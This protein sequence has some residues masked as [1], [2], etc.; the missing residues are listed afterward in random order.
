MGIRIRRV[1]GPAHAGELYELQA[2]CLP[3]D[4]PC[5][6]DIGEWWIAFEED[7]AIAFCCLSRSY[8]YS[9]CGYL[10]RSGVILAHRGHGLQKR[11]I[12][13]RVRRARQ[14]GYRLVFT[15]T[16]RNPESANSLIR[17]GFKTYNP[18]KPYGKSMAMIYWRKK[19]I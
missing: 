18:A 2:K 1:N 12:R 15:D 6:V 8:R 4:T 11:L 19:L 17:C 9:N 10:A 7:E 13:A 14:L 3:S 16:L 5:S